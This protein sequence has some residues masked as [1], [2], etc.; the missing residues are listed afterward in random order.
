MFCVNFV[1][2]ANTLEA[3]GVRLNPAAAS[4]SVANCDD[5]AEAETQ[6]T[7]ISGTDFLDSH[8]EFTGRSKSLSNC[9]LNSE[10][11]L[12]GMS[13][14]DNSVDSD[15]SKSCVIPSMAN[16][17]ADHISDIS[18]QTTDD[19]CSDRTSICDPMPVTNCVSVE[20]DVVSRLQTVQNCLS[21]EN[22]IRKDSKIVDS[23]PEDCGDLSVMNDDSRFEDQEVV[24]EWLQ[25]TVEHLK[26]ITSSDENDLDIDLEIQD[27]E[28]VEV[29]EFYQEEEIAEE[30]IGSEEETCSSKDEDEN[31]EPLSYEL[32]QGYKILREIMGNNNRSFTWPFVNPV[33]S[34]AEGCADYYEKV[35]KPMWLMKSKLAVA[36]SQRLYCSFV[37]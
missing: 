29:Q 32:Q 28:T 33:D 21:V 5:S 10:T 1:E 16:L 37:H 8:L 11:L 31:E 23:S 34:T 7:C 15:S 2:M 6:T 26:R 13:L 24:K 19:L 17:S 9:K 25:G 35:K 20:P 18:Y 22:E 14:A 27:E 4:D 3:D 12:V 30:T 36:F